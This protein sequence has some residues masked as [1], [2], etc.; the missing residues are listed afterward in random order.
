MN[1]KDPLQGYFYFGYIE[2][3]HQNKP[4]T[5]AKVGHMWWHPIDNTGTVEAYNLIMVG[6]KF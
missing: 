3:L 6:W 5:F 2:Y 4:G 1:E